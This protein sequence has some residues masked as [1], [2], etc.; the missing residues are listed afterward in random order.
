[1]VAAGF[2]GDRDGRRRDDNRPPR[3]DNRDDSPHNQNR[4]WR[5]RQPRDD[6]R[7]PRSLKDQL[8]GPCQFH[9]F[10]DEQGELRSRHTLRNCRRFN[11]LSEAHDREAQ[12]APQPLAN[13]IQGQIAHDAPPAP[14]I[15]PRQV[16]SVQQQHQALNDEEEYPLAH[17]RICMIQEERPSNRQQKQATRQVY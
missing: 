5:P 3:H 16:A 17:G 11:Q 6:N 9:Y 10:K 4:E 7:A 1:M 14:P 2:P 13:I 15:Q 12:P 8:D